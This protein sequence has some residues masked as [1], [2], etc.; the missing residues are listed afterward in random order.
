MLGKWSPENGFGGN[1]EEEEENPRKTR[2]F[3]LPP[4][5]HKFNVKTDVSGA[6]AACTFIGRMAVFDGRAI[7]FV[8]FRYPRGPPTARHKIATF[9]DRHVDLSI[10]RVGSRHCRGTF[11]SSGACFSLLFR[12][13]RAASRSA[14]KCSK[15]R[16]CRAKCAFEDHM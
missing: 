10:C 1:L 8:I 16:P 2:I 7:T 12:H 5:T 9:D 14:K 13:A 4:K 11:P 3:R 15:P 6:L